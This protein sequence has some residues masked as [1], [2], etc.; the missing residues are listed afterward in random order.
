M[1]R[2]S[3]AQGNRPYASPAAQTVCKRVTSGPQNAVFYPFSFQ[4]LTYSLGIEHSTT[5]LQSCCSALFF[6]PSVFCEGLSI[7]F[8]TTSALFRPNTGRG[9][10]P[11]DLLFIFK[12]LCTLQSLRFDPAREVHPPASSEA[13]LIDTKSLRR[14]CR[15]LPRRCRGNTLSGEA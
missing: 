1:V 14:K 11:Q 5:P 9:Y 8:S 15:P 13:G 4:S 3:L 7:P 10:T 2:P 12:G 6:T